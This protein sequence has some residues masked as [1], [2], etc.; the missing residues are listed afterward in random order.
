MDMT[1][2][3]FKKDAR[4]HILAHEVFT[5]WGESVTTLESFSK[6]TKTIPYEVFCSL[7]PRIPR[8]YRLDKN[9]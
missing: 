9:V 2:V 8:I 7:L 5:I 4:E 6:Q 1:H 3:F